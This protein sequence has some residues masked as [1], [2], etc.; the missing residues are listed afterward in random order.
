MKNNNDASHKCIGVN[1]KCTKFLQHTDG[2]NAYLI[3]FYND[4]DRVMIMPITE[5][6]PLTCLSANIGLTC[7]HFVT[8]LFIVCVSS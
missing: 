8:L 5:T 7:L 6:L 4:C 3:K 1:K 2:Q